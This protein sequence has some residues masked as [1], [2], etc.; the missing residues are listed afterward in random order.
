MDC[1]SC[2]PLLRLLYPHQRSVQHRKNQ[3][4]PLKNLTILTTSGFLTMFRNTFLR[5]TYPSENKLDHNWRFIKI[6]HNLYEKNRTGKWW[7]ITKPLLKT[8]SYSRLAITALV[9]SE[10]LAVPPKS[11]VRGPFAIVSSTAFSILSAYAFKLICLN[12]ITDESSK[13]VGLAKSFPAISGAVPWTCV[14]CKYTFKNGSLLANISRRCQTKTTNQ[15]SSQITKNI[16]VKIRHDHY[17]IAKQCRILHQL[18]ANF[19]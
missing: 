10:F 19:V 8:S 14:T 12:I 3:L 2:F 6:D 4:S 1:L 11:P 18:Q 13:A 5:K 15:P 16:P 17:S 7:D 9:N